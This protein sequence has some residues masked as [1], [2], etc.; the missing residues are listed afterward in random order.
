MSH[1][2]GDW[3]RS[4][5]LQ[6]PG[7]ALLLCLALSAAPARALVQ[8]HAQSASAHPTAAQLAVSTSPVVKAPSG[9]KGW[10]TLSTSQQQS[11]AP[12]AGS[13]NSLS[14]SHQRKWL[15]LSEN[16]SKLTVPEQQVLHSRMREWAALSTRQR[17]QARLNFGEATQM[18]G[19]DKKAMWEAYQALPAEEKKKLAAGAQAKPPTT[20][21]AVKPVAKQKL[22]TLPRSVAEARSP[23]IAAGPA[24]E[25]GSQDAAPGRVPAG[26]PQ[27]AH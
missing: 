6:R 27:Q 18:T 22:A 1:P 16:F 4:G 5:L 21:A 17:A 25:A 13:W 24:L 26:A 2:T 12:L 11:L 19:A 23:R 8:A 14:P 15:A 3:S 10:G 7:T 9:G 20:A